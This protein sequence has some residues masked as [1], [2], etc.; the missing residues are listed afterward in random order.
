MANT[1]KMKMVLKISFL[2][3]RRHVLIKIEQKMKLIQWLLSN[4]V[5]QFLVQLIDKNI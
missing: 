3:E 5:E 2:H 1:P 4:N